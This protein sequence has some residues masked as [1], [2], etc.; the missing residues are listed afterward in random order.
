M[1]NILS[2]IVAALILWILISMIRNPIMLKMSF[3]NA[4]RRKAETL[5]VVLGSLIGTALIVGSMAMNDSFQKFL[6]AQV[7][8][9]LG[10]IDEI[11]KPGDGKPYFDAEKLMEQLS[12]LEESPLTDGVLPV[13]TRNVTIGFPGET[14]KLNPEKTMEAFLIGGDPGKFS[15]FVGKDADVKAFELLQGDSEGYVPAIINKKIADSL[16]VREG[17]LLEILPDASYRLLSWIKLPMIKIMGVMDQAGFI[18]YTGSEMN[19]MKGTLLL[20]INDARKILGISIP[21]AFSDIFVSNKGDYLKGEKLTSQVVDFINTHGDFFEIETVK[22]EVISDASQGNIGLV[23]L[24][25]S[26]FAIVAGVFL[27]INIYVM[28]SEE[29]KVE[30]G[31]LRAIGFKRSEV[32]KVIAF[33]GFFYSLFA[34]LAGIPAGLLITK[35]ILS[36]FVNLVN[37]ITVLISSVGSRLNT[38]TFEATFDLYVKPSTLIY[39]FMLGMMIPILVSLYAGRKISRMNIVRA[40]RNIPEELEIEKKSFKLLSVISV[41]VSVLIAFGGYRLENASLFVLGVVLALFAL[42]FV[43]PIKKKRLIVSLFCVAALGFIFWSNSVDFVNKASS[44]SITLIAIKGFSI[45][46]FVMLLGTYNLKIFEWVLLR[47]FKRSKKHTPTLKISISFP[48]RNRLTTAMTIAMYAMVVYIITVISIIPYTQ[49][50]NLS[51]SRNLFLYGY[52]VYASSLSGET[53][54]SATEIS[55]IEGVIEASTILVGRA[56]VFTSS[57]ESKRVNLYL[58]D[59]RFPGGSSFAIKNLKT[60]NPVKGAR[61][62]ISVLWNYLV[63]HPDAI[64]VSES[65]LKADPGDRVTITEISSGNAFA[66]PERSIRETKNVWIPLERSVDLSVVGVIP[67]DTFSIFNGIFIYS[68]SLPEE[69]VAKLGSQMLFI[70]LEGDN[71]EEKKNNHEKVRSLIGM[72]GMFSIFIDDILKIIS[73]SISGIVEIFRSFL[74][75]G[76]FVGIAGTAITMFKAFYR[77]KRIIGILKSLGFTRNMIFT[78][79]WVEASFSVIIGLL[80]GFLTGILTTYE[81]FSSP[82]LEGLNFYIPWYQL[83]VMGVSFYVISLLSTFVPSYFAS[84]LP[85]ARAIRYFE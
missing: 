16:G 4:F 52:D 41:S 6:Y 67:E 48:A 76:M 42:P 57:G 23:F 60:I 29:R 70:K 82:A 53:T 12:L 55:S 18:N 54:I 7:E 14:R 27:L 9:N 24:A 78:S 22:S 33:E 38:S 44:D 61:S 28:L 25:L 21:D 47:L 34:A 49:E 58:I 35:F 26:L 43:I 8:Y 37:N 69:I 36:K 13:I 3:K 72:S 56:K 20:N 19:P 10:E 62:D 65:V 59:K 39:G 75:F 68:E 73:A 11:L 77:R 40:V 5:L 83:M 15:N 1:I 31:T 71:Y 84:R 63:S 50:K 45:L 32:S 74:Y 66:G 51:E 79:F 30:L 64:A 46:L 81:M 85:P 2:Y 17:D 80:L